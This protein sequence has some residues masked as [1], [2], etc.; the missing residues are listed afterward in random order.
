MSSSS[1]SLSSSES[2]RRKVDLT[3]RAQTRFVANAVDGFRFT[4]AA[5]NA[6]LMP[7]EIFRYIRRPY[8]PATGAEADEFDGVCSV[9]DLEELPVGAPTGSP[10]FFRLAELDL[11][12]RSM[13]EADEAWDVIRADVGTLVRTLNL[14][15]ELG[16]A[17]T[18]E[19]D[20]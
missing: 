12:F 9:P 5:E 13:T 18:T 7:A 11:V 8:N 1:S 4:V 2:P 19:I 3:R 6:V 14:A 10:Q 20:G 15:D 17:E 16:A